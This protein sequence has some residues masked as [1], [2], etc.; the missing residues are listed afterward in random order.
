MRL[1]KISKKG[2]V[3]RYPYSLSMLQFE[4][5]NVSFPENVEANILS[6]FD[7]YQVYETEKP[8]CT[9]NQKIVEVNP[10]YVDGKWYQSWKLENLTEEELELYID[11][12]SDEVRKTRNDLLSESDWTQLEDAPADKQNWKI[13]RQK[14][15]DITSQSGFPLAIIWPNKPE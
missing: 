15:R 7:V 8:L 14:L 2:N 6:Q 5:P 3:I 1:V 10:V 12:K 13:Y 9:Y 11:S 4:F